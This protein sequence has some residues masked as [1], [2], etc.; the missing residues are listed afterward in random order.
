MKP[1]FDKKIKWFEAKARELGLDFFPINFEIVPEEV[2]LEIMAYGLPTRSRHWSYG[3]SYEYNKIYGEM[4]MSKV[5]EVVLNNDPSYAFLLD[6]NLD[7]AN[8]M[9]V[10]HVI[11]HVHFF[12]NNN[13][14]K[15]SDR[16]MVFHAAERAQRV[17]EYIQKY[18]IERVEHIMDVGFSMDHNIDWFKGIDRK[19]YAKPKKVL[20]EKKAKE[21]DD[22]M[23]GTGPS[24]EEVQLNKKFPPT[25]EF[26]LIWFLMNYSNLDDWE[27]DILSIIREESFYFYPQ[28]LT[29]IMN[30]GFASY[31]HAELM[32]LLDHSELKSSDHLEFC[33][34]HERVVQPGGDPTNINPYFLGFTIFN[35]IKERWDE[36]FNNGESEITGFQKILQVVAEEDD[37]SFLR[38]YLTQTIVDELGMFSYISGKDKHGEFIDIESRK[39]KDVVESMAS[40]R[41]NYQAPLISIVRAASGGLELEHDSSEVGTLD[42]KHLGKVMGYL[43]EIWGGIID[44]K[45]VDENGGTIHYTYDEVGFSD[46]PEEDDTTVVD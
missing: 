8:I 26:D 3:Q 32:Y 33:K 36:L 31:M 40:K 42:P 43:Q 19:P 35:D 20:K 6:T 45:T 16:K 11:G 17:D 15:D 10:A 44:L 24:F 30:E 4:G 27:K 38:N 12:K 34:L 18:G 13:L 22:M 46:Y 39:V 37:V 2:M 5:Y 41:Y 7:I 28:Y 23:G 21:F 14:F 29:K 1:E 25:K 9:V